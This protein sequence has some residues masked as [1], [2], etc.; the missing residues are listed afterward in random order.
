M[1]LRY[2]DRLSEAEWIDLASFIISVA[3]LV[4]KRIDG[5]DLSALDAH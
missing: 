1:E 2:P 4:R 3:W 5:D